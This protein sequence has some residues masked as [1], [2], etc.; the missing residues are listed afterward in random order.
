MAKKQANHQRELAVEIGVSQSTVSKMLK[1]PDWPVKRRAAPWPARDITAIQQWRQT[2]QEDR[3]REDS[4]PPA[5]DLA[6]AHKRVKIL[7]DSE[8]AAHEKLKRISFPA[9]STIRSNPPS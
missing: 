4:Q 6:T 9:K 5:G 8:R 1:R 3:A 2:L 7:L